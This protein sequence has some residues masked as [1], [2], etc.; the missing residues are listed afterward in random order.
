MIADTH[1]DD[2]ERDLINHILA[3]I[4]ER[5][6]IAKQLS[7]VHV[8]DDRFNQQ[9]FAD[10]ANQLELAHKT[11]QR[12]SAMIETLTAELP[13][14]EV[15]QALRSHSG[16]MHAVSVELRGKIHT[17]LVPSLGTENPVDWVRWW[18]RFTARY[19]VP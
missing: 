14:N 4:E 6:V 15:I 13:P 19:G 2:R 1:S 16:K 7:T 9:R 11:I 3:T 10:M 5:M 17:F 8:H 18:Q 12:L